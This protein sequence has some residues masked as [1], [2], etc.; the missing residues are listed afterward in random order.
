MRRL[1][2]QTTMSNM[3]KGLTERTG[4]TLSEAQS[5]TP[6]PEL[7]PSTLKGVMYMKFR[8]ALLA[9]LLTVA[10]VAA[11]SAS[12][13]GTK[14]VVFNATYAGVAN[15]VVSDGVSTIT[16]TGA[17]K[18]TPIGASKLTGKGAGSADET[19]E[20][21]AFAGTGQIVGLKGAKINFKMASSQGC[22][23]GTDFSITGRALVSGGAGVY[24]K[25]KGNLKVVG[26]WNKT[27]K[28]FSIKFIG[29]LT[30]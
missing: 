25:A 17:G 18:G 15:V 2:P 3:W 30:V 22:G 26:A 28:K 23:D 8:I 24:K 14:I 20:C 5:D 13:A 10:A 16:A 21:N 12:A 11:G 4:V 1:G 27:T 29:K 19:A 7:S 9:A 6:S